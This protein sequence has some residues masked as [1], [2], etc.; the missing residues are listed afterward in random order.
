[1]RAL[2]LNGVYASKPNAGLQQV[3]GGN[4]LWKHP[5]LSFEDIPQPIPSWNDVI[6]EVIAC[7]ICGSDLHCIETDE[8]GY[9]LFSGPARLPVIL[10]H[11]FTGRVVEVGRDVKDIQ[12]GQIVAAE[13]VQACFHCSTCL[14][15]HLNQCENIELVGLTVNGAL[16]PYVKVKAA[17]CYSIDP[18]LER[19]GSEIGSVTGTLLEPLGCAYNALFINGSGLRPT[20]RIAIFGAGPIGLSFIALARSVGVSLIIAFDLIDERV[21][22]A[23]ALGADAAFNTN[24]LSDN[25]LSLKQVIDQISE[26]MGVTIAVEASGSTQVFAPAISVL[27]ARGTLIYVGRASSL[28]P[29]D[30]NLLV[31]NALHIIGS[32]G[33]AGYNIYPALIQLIAQGKLNLGSFITAGFSFKDSIQ[34]IQQACQRRDGKVIIHLDN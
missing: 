28:I 12:C 13:S 23:K 10:G 19:Y 4:A 14:S 26:G 8:S 6:I 7:G 34:G 11:E 25:G 22:L 32:R 29:F 33:H 31:S 3:S 17:H 21:E 9:M 15:G 24:Q 18:I 27:A 2:V 5:N 30:P 1:M 20:D 16:A